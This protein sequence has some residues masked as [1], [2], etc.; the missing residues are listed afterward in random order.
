[1]ENTI[2]TYNIEL[3][4][5]TPVHIGT[6][7]DYVPVDYV[8]KKDNSDNINYLYFI[9]RNKFMNFIFKDDKYDQFLSICSD[10]NFMKINKFISDNFKPDMAEWKIAVSKS[11]L[12][13]YMNNMQ[14]QTG[15]NEKNKLEIRAFVRDNFQ[16]NIYI[17]GSSV[18]GS[19]RTAVLN[20]YLKIN[21]KPFIENTYG[22][23]L[24]SVDIEKHILKIKQKDN[25]D[26]PFRFIKI[27]DFVPE[28]NDKP[29]SFIDKVINYKSGHTL[30]EGKGVPVIMELSL[31]EKKFIGQITIAESKFLNLEYLN[32]EY[33]KKSMDY[34]YGEN[35]YK[36]ESS[37]FPNI[38]IEPV[39]KKYEEA[40]KEVQANKGF[41]MKIGNHSGAFEVSMEGYRKI[42]IK[43]QNG[44][45]TEGDRQTTLWINE[46]N[47]LPLGWVKCIIK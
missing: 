13:T 2:K 34:H 28:N 1:M 22:K 47:K 16:K 32:I 45:Y 31:R 46:V 44:N 12:E 9:N 30:I 8:I 26:D 43:T 18:K 4:T 40:K 23:E 7:E 20:Y 41:L 5:I 19:I 38:F 3:S 15:K 14:F 27:S 33:I 24:K 35:S 17:P 42:K 37:A 6:G 36:F 39:I 10:N 21:G 29:Y 25:S 11:V